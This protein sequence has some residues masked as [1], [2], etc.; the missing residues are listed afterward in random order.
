VARYQS[1]LCGKL[2]LLKPVL[3]AAKKNLLV[4]SGAVLGPL[5]CSATNAGIAPINVTVS[6]LLLVRLNTNNPGLEANGIYP[7]AKESLAST[8]SRQGTSA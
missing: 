3:L 8:P 5:T 7:R 1:A 4:H 2:Q 6:L